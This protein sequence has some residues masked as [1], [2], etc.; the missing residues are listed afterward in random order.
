MELTKHG[1]FTAL[2][3]KEIHKHRRSVQFCKTQS[4]YAALAVLKLATYT[5]PMVAFSQGNHSASASRELASPVCQA[6]RASAGAA[7][8]ASPCPW[9][10]PCS[11]THYLGTERSPR[12]P[13]SI[14]QLLHFVLTVPLLS[15]K[16]NQSVISIIENVACETG[17]PK[18][19]IFRTY[20]VEVKNQCFQAVLHLHMCSMAQLGHPAPT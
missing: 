7:F 12:Q 13:N 9:S 1:L 4:C 15:P 14:T 11:S 2:Q 16:G 17:S 18:L 8:W 5:Q 19:N 20:M 10:S 3:L 6:T